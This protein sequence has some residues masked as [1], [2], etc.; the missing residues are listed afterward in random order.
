MRI[1][2]SKLRQIIRE[3]LARMGSDYAPKE[4]AKNRA[5]GILLRKLHDRP[6]PA[7]TSKDEYDH[8]VDQAVSEAE[9]D[10][11]DLAKMI[12]ATLRAIP[13]HIMAMMPRG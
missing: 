5:Q 3:E 8:M 13:P 11:P 2:E 9:I 4:A 10:D 1:T 7:A 6:E 12:A